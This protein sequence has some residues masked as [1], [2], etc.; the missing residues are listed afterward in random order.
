MAGI[1]LERPLVGR[2]LDIGGGGEGIIG[3]VYGQS[4]TAI[5]CRQEELDE[6]PDC[7]TK[8]CMDAAQ[9]QFGNG[10]FDH[11]TFFFSLLYMDTD[12]Q[13]KAICE[14]ARVL[15]PGGTITI[16]DCAV[17]SAYPKPFL[18]ELEIGANGEQVHTTYGVVKQGTQSADAF[19]GMCRAAGLTLR[20]REENGN[21]FKLTFEKRENRQR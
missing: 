5:D 20:A 11:A 14:A 8:L 9:L 4:V 13:Q 18:I 7:C 10:S 17:A 1:H 16:W 2:I 21:T 19:L 6:A 15:R 12:T 3:R